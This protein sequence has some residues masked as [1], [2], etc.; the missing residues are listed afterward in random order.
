MAVI[1]CIAGAAGGLIIAAISN[2]LVLPMVLPVIGQ[3]IAWPIATGRSALTDIEHGGD[4]YAL[5][6][7]YH[8]RLL[9]GSLVYSQQKRR[10]PAGRSDHDWRR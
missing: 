5:K 4:Y 8:R 3:Q 1:I 2:W 10:L 9:S 6:I 7:S